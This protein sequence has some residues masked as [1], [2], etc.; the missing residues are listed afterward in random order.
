RLTER[1]SAPVVLG[2]L[3]VALILVVW[4]SVARLGWVNP[5][6]TSQP[7]ASAKV[8]AEE[9]RSGELYHN[10]SVSLREFALGFGAAIVVGLILGIMAGRYRTFEYVLDPF[11]WLVYSAPLIAFYPIFVI[12]FGLGTHTVIA[13]TFL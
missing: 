7:T 8:L 1:R 11:I 9:A 2:I 3:S 4:E 12:W 13:I 10:L 6:F 5:F